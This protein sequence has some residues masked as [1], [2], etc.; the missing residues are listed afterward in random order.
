[1]D[2]FATAYR[3]WVKESLRGLG[4]YRDGKW[5]ESVAV[6][7][8]AFVA[9]TKEKLGVK[10][11]GRKVIGGSGS[12]ELRQTPVPYRGITGYENGV[13]RPANEYFWMDFATIS[14]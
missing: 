13:P 7:G 3:E 11:K 12:Y 4:L 9:A 14:V 6:G 2:D 8:A 1:M 5:T 10:A